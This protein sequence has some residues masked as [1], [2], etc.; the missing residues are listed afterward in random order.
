[1][2]MF[3]YSPS[4]FP[5]FWVVAFSIFITLNGCV[6]S[7][8]LN[9][10]K[11]LNDIRLGRIVKLNGKTPS[12]RFTVLN[13]SGLE[14]AI[15]IDLRRRSQKKIASFLNRKKLQRTFNINDSIAKSFIKI[16]MSILALDHLLHI[17]QEEKV[18]DNSKK[19]SYGLI[20]SSS[21]LIP[22]KIVLEIEKATAVFLVG[23][24]QNKSTLQIIDQNGAKKNF[25]LSE[26]LFVRNK[27]KVICSSYFPLN[28]THKFEL[29]D[30]PRKCN[31]HKKRKINSLL[32]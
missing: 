9:D 6:L 17:A 26:G 14:T 27:I 29:V 31:Y 24:N 1:M 5:F 19:H 22:E 28:Q 7:R 20:T 32:K 21:Y 8:G 30:N 18:F 11:P 4:R 3:C 10:T 12:A 25:S 2:R 15:Q 13:Y 16:D 23:L